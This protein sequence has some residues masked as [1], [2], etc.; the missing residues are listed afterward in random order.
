[1]PAAMTIGELVGLI[2]ADDTRFTRALDSAERR[3]G[4]LQRALDGRLRDLHR[5]F[6][7]ETGSMAHEVADNVAAGMDAAQEQLRGFQRDAAGR[8]RDL[9]GR[10]ASESRAMAD[11]LA[12]GVQDGADRADDALRRLADDASDHAQEMGDQLARD[13]EEAGERLGDGIARGANQRMRDAQGRFVAAGDQGGQ[14]VSRGMLGRIRAAFSEGIGSAVSGGM[15]GLR[16]SMSGLKE[17]PYVKGIGAAMA[18]GV[19]ATLLP[20]I[21]ALMSGAIIYGGGMQVIELGYALLKEEPEVKRASKSLTETAKRIFT[22]AAEPMKRPFVNAF[23]ALEGTVKDLQPHIRA[24]FEGAAGFVKPLQEGVSALATNALPGFA[25]MMKEGQ[26]VFDALR[27]VLDQ[28]GEGLNTMF[29]AISTSGPEAGQA[30]RDVGTAIKYMLIAVGYTLAGLA[31]AYDVIRG[32]IGDVIDAFKWLYN[33]LVGN[34]IIPD[35][36][37][38]IVAWF[39]SLPGRAWNALATLGTNIAARARDAGT[40]MVRAIRSALDSAVTW[41]KGLP[42][43]ASD[44]LGNL[45]QV[46]RYSGQ[47]LIW[48]FVD[49]MWSM[50]SSVTS[51]AGALVSAARDYFPFSPAKKGPFSGRG[52]TTHS[53]RALVAGFEEGITGRLPHLRGVLAHLGDGMPDAFPAYAQGGV[54]RSP[55]GG[56]GPGGTVGGGRTEVLVRFDTTGANEP[57]KALLRQIVKVDGGGN[58]QAAFGRG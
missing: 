12:D 13:G 10:F 1:M 46:L 54:L 43:R 36:V 40:S 50:L 27:D 15:S 33:V 28:I 34:S 29:L 26:P 35:L 25:R 3:M 16:D 7:D 57:M 41:V 4:L 8:L 24:M 38:A 23:K 45:G 6:R 19:V 37:N 22:E 20:M 30:L 56:Y 32:F 14:D 21:G 51:T 49:G 17:N 55:G 42:G 58:V 52:Y 44:A 31:D 47:S 9:R 48:G 53:G 39:K 5:E 18:A 2:R 11:A